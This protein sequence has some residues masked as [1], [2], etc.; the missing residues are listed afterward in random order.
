M[1]YLEFIVKW[2]LGVPLTIFGL[3]KFLLFADM[4]PPTGEVA[5]TFLGAMFTSY[6]AKFVGIIEIVGGVLLLVNRTSFLG[7]LLLS[8]VV[9]N[10][11][12]FHVAHDLPGNGIWMFTMITF[13]VVAYTQRNE[14]QYLIITNNHG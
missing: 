12:L 1:K 7:L 4:P 13:L 6:L 8:P 9:A 2:L 14:F 11:V 10:I 5:Q 3:N